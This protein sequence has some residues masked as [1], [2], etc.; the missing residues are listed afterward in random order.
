MTAIGM[1]NALRTMWHC[2]QRQYVASVR[3]LCRVATD[4]GSRASETD[5]PVLPRAQAFYIPWGAELQHWAHTHPEYTRQQTAALVAAI[6]EAQNI[7]KRDRVAA[8]AEIQGEL[9]MV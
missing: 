6:A 1:L 7:R 9:A 3:S 5:D 2:Q 4:A 8:L